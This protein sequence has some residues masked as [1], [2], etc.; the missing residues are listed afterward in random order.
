MTRLYLREDLREAWGEVELF[1]RVFVLEGELYRAIANR[2]TLR[3]EIGGRGYFAKT[4]ASSGWGEI[5]KNLLTLRLPVV[6]ARNEYLACR[7]LEA[8]GIRAPTVAAYGVRGW[9]P[10]R[11][12]SFIVCD[13]LDGFESLEELA[14]RWQHTPPTALEQRRLVMAVAAF[15]RR[16]HEAGMVHRDFYICHLLLDQAAYAE[17]RIELAVLD[18]HR[19]IIYPRIPP[20]WRQRDL[21]ALLYS[22]M[23]LPL[24]R[25]A[26]YRFLR[27]Y[28]DRP[29]KQIFAEDGAFWAAV[30]RRARAL[31]EKGVRKGYVTTRYLP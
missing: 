10:A 13:A 26:W 4:H 12:Q 16:F 5:V 2:R 31:F 8:R 3:F 9:S 6:S 14:A 15:A 25:R 24:S 1:E 29:L 7:H 18:L 23:E 27:V 30:E 20:R 19:A 28:C 11:R 21:A 17:G 22:T